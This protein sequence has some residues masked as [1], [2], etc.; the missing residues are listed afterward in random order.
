MKRAYRVTTR[1]RY[2]ADTTDTVEASSIEAVREMYAG[3][4]VISITE[5]DLIERPYRI[6]ARSSYGTLESFVIPALDEADARKCAD[7]I[8]S[9]EAL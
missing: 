2:T 5:T 4:I 8:I 9:I 1:H 7:R 3:E 6:T